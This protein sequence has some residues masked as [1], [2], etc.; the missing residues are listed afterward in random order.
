MLLF[1]AQLLFLP[2]APHIC[3][4]LHCL[5]YSTQRRRAFIT[6]KMAKP[7]A[8]R[9]TAAG[10]ARSGDIMCALAN[11]RMTLVACEGA[12]ALAVHPLY[13]NSTGPA[14]MSALECGHKSLK[15]QAEQR[16]WWF[17]CKTQMSGGSTRLEDICL[18]RRA[19]RRVQPRA[20]HA[21]V[22]HIVHRRL[23]RARDCA[24]HACVY[25][26]SQSTPR[27]LQQQGGTS[28][29]LGG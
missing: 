14:H 26:S 22:R 11:V 17:S 3:F 29:Q 20:Q 2:P 27:N 10:M 13:L 5:I 8:S 16:N 21:R 18:Q 7:A 28:E 4:S 15:R 1:L 12:R 24:C 6:V 9:S 25:V 19:Q 23:H